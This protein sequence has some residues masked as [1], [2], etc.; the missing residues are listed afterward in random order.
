MSSNVTYLQVEDI[1]LFSALSLAVGESCDI[2]DMV[3]VAFF[4]R[5][6]S[7]QG[8]KELLG[9]LPLTG[10]T[11]GEDIANA[12]QK[13]LEHSKIDLNKIVSIATDGAR[14]MTGKNKGATMI[15]QSKIKHEI[16]TF[17]CITHQEALYA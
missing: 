15:L 2:K 10:Q 17:H 3:Q 9:L 13:C 8:T 16:L 5:Y 1:Q 4:V 12:E 7:S 6:M 11:R 14:S